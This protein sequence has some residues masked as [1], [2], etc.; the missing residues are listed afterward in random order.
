MSLRRLGDRQSLLKTLD[1]L[2]PGRRL[3]V[4]QGDAH[5]ARAF[6]MLS[7]QRMARALDLSREPRPLRERYGSNRQG[8]GLLV[9]RRLVEAGVTYVLVNASRNND[10]DTH[11]DNFNLLKNK[12]LPPMDRGV[13]ALVQDLDER[14]LLDETLVVVMSEMGRTPTIGGNAGRDHWPDAFSVLLAGGGLT[15]GQVLGS[16]TAGGH[17]PG[18]RPVPLGDILATIYHQLGIDTDTLLYDE[19]K[20][21]FPILP[22]ARAV[23]ELL[24]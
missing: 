17:K 16:T 9:A 18:E 22:D 21:P 4:D 14:G 19:L 15:R 6:H 10:W 23:R 24:A 3:G 7:T 8:Q 20:R 13:A 2:E 5:H 12:L 11:A 1:G